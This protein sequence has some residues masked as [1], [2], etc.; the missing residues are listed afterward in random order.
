M[1]NTS[2]ITINSLIQAFQH[3]SELNKASA[4]HDLLM[5]YYK[6]SALERSAV[7]VAMKPFLAEIEQE[8]IAIEP[9]AQEVDQLL[10]RVNKH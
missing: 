8:M 7:R 5:H 3:A 4:K 2:E 9:F 10:S 1:I 6:L